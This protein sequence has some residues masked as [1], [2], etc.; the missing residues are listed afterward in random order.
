MSIFSKLL[1]SD[2][3]KTKKKPIHKQYE[4]WS[5]PTLWRNDDGVMIGANGQAW[6][7][8]ALELNPMKW[9]DDEVRLHIG[10]KLERLLA[11][12]GQ[13]SKDP[14][15]GIAALSN[16]REIHI[17]S[18]TWQEVLTPPESNP[19]ALNA[20]QQDAYVFSV[21]QRALFVGVRL[22]PSIMGDK[23]DKNGKNI[24][25]TMEDLIR[26][27]IAE[28][29]P[30]VELYK[31]DIQKVRRIFDKHSAKIP[32]AAQYDQLE[33][34]FNQGLGSDVLIEEQADQLI[35]DGTTPLQMSA[36]RR[37]DS[38]TMTAPLD[39]WVMDTLSHPEDAP[40]VVSIRAELEPSKVT[41]ERA[42][43]SQRKIQANIEEEEASG[44]LERAEFT[45]TYQA[46]KELEANLAN[47][48]RPMLSSVSIVMAREVSDSA[49]TYMDFLDSAYGI[50]VTTLEH[51][52]ILALDET[53]PCSD[54]RVNPFLQDVN[55][56]MIAHAGLQA[57]SSLGDDRG[58]FVGFIDPD[59]APLFLD[60]SASSRL[61]YPPA[62][63]VF[64]DPGSG[65]S[66]PVNTPVFKSSG[67]LT[68]MGGLRPGDYILGAQGQ[69]IRVETIHPQGV[70]S[71]YNVTLADGRALPTSDQHLWNVW[72]VQNPEDGWQNLELRTFM[73]K[74][75]LDDGSPR[76]S[77]KVP[78]PLDTEEIALPEDPYEVGSSG[79]IPDLYLSGS[80]AQREAVL[81][82]LLESAGEVLPD[83]VFQINDVDSD[84]A[85]RVAHL[86]CSLGGVP[87]YAEEDA[88]MQVELPADVCADLAEDLRSQTIQFTLP[89]VAVTE[90]G[91]DEHVCITVDADDRLYVS[92]DF[93]VSHNTFFAQNFAT[94]CVLADLPVFFINPKAADPLTGMVDYINEQTPASATTTS[95]MKATEEPG[96][97]DPFR[98]AVEPTYAAEVASKFILTALS[99]PRDSLPTEVRL[100][101]E[102][103]LKRGALNGAKCVWDALDFITSKDHRDYLKDLIDKQMDASA[104]FALGIA[105][106]PRGRLSMLSNHLNLV[107]FDREIG[108]P[109]GS[110]PDHYEVSERI[111]I[112]TVNL[113]TKAA[114]E[115]LIA[116]RG[117]VLILDEAWTFL[118]QNES[119]AT[120]QR[121]SREG[122]SLNIVPVF[123]TQRI[124]DAIQREME[125][126]FS[127]ILVLKLTDDTEA[128]E[129]MRICG[130]EATKER[131]ALLREAGPK[132]PKGDQPAV[133]AQG[134]FRDLQM[135][136]AWV[137]LGPTP[138]A[139]MK[140]WSTNPEDKRRA[141]EERLRKLEESQ[142]E[143]TIAGG[144]QPK[145]FEELVADAGLTDEDLVASYAEPD[146]VVQPE[147]Q[148]PAPPRN[149]FSTPTPAWATPEPESSA[150]EESKPEPQGESAPKPDSPFSTPKPFWE[151]SEAGEGSESEKPASTQAT[152]APRPE[153]GQPKPDSPFSTP[154]PFW[155]TPEPEPEEPQE[156]EQPRSLFSK[157]AAGSS[158]AGAPKRR[159]TF[160]KPVGH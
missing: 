117:G 48:Q 33:S 122:R 62:F 87:L 52:Q 128:R 59:G 139:A 65:K 140:A 74:L 97:F 147:E 98:F 94:Q 153:S 35:V 103:G 21:P 5:T 29:V 2:D 20:Y 67:E 157:P 70:L 86:T 39:Q 150:S 85:A 118:Q 17:E 22:L 127:R 106:R 160:S 72:D 49:E 27:A 13:L 3:S 44:D 11:D 30:E 82:G 69:P 156:Q 4:Q 71:T 53:L 126:Y 26:R 43:R 46:A 95:I 136:H 68:T 132:P 8:R 158:E 100:S 107:S 25:R 125:S 135:R 115:I 146:D 130:L 119:M 9:E 148:E 14:V 37:F 42:R 142:Q 63:G 92:G 64:G 141:E 12:L 93:V 34:H 154:K 80:I 84:M 102:S 108:L 113:V 159:P 78:R 99:P 32:T 120:L 50:Q 104:L 76:F 58:C 6:L 110:N 41:R 45:E 19:P 57:F 155:E 55:V 40:H 15:G 47:D 134:M 151:E 81:R 16:N 56:P 149:P 121:I 75:F 112:A 144:H 145:G 77:V 133:W 129:A 137:A 91:E 66:S 24:Y 111:A 61:N 31:S 116:N 143:A 60:P 79:E 7:Y 73:G 23:K 90:A 28:D 36:I 131:M 152:T 114:L 83:G 138:E 89:I 88:A 18:I 10:Q 123:L 51:R 101:L 109:S 96:A 1:K 38:P 124:N 54:V 105:K